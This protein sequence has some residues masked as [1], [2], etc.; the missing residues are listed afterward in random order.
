MKEKINLVISD[1]NDFRLTME[2]LNIF[3]EK[4]LLYYGE[5]N[6]QNLEYF[7]YNWMTYFYMMYS[8]IQKWGK[9]EKNE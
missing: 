5:T 6:L 7:T 4:I 2:E 1:L 8:E 9:E 3:F